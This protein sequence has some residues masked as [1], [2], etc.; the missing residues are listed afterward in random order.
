MTR[1]RATTAVCTRHSRRPSVGLR[2]ATTL[3]G[4][5]GFTGA[6]TTPVNPSATPYTIT[7]T[8]G[9]LAATNY[10][11]TP[12]NDGALTISKAHLTVKADDK[13]KSYDGSVYAP[14]T[15]TISGFANCDNFVRQR[16]L[17]GRGHHGGQRQRHALHDHADSGHPGGH[18][19]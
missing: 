7:P 4:S 9:T 14:F 15:A 13:N 6:A 17:H 16:R 3:S 8:V 10:D 5:A 11:F 12:F 1:T 18:Q 19:L 2:T